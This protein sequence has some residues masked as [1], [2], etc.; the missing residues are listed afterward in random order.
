VQVAEDAVRAEFESRRASLTQAET[1]SIIQIS[2]P[3]QAKAQAA[4]TRLAA[5]EDADAVASALGLQ[6]VRYDQTEQ[7][8][9]A[10]AGVRQAAFAMAE[11]ATQTVQGRLTPWAAVRVVEIVPGVTP[12]YAD[13]A[14]ELRAE[15]ALHEAT[16]LQNT[17]MEAFDDARS[18]GASVTDAARTA[19]LTTLV[20]PA[21][22]A[23]GADPNGQPVPALAG[24]DTLLQAAFE[25]LEGES[26]EFAPDGEN[27]YVLLGVN[28]ITPQSTR[29]LADVRE[30]LVAAWT[31][32]ARAQ[33]MRAFSDEVTQAVNGG[34]PFAEVARARG[35][36]IVQRSVTL[37]RE[38]A[39]QIPARNIAGLIYAAREGQLVADVR[40]DAQSIIFALVESIERTDPATAPDQV[41]MGRMQMQQSLGQSLSEAVG[42]EAIARAKPRR[43]DTLIERYYAPQTGEDG[44]QTQ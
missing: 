19:G 28:S 10:D 6:A 14:A 9:V 27:A 17:A 41:E 2:A 4:A 40:A 24:Q 25:T 30:E 11:G 32:R 37:D 22:S 3:D 16:E 29:P 36:R 7:A 1:R 38:G 31:A 18:G 34:S 33:R 26:T 42:T 8:G 20:V 12:T 39:A 44:E 5:G 13:V 23:Q 21:V 35:L 15:L 43:N